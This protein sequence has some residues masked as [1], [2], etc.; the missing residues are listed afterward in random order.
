MKQPDII[1][2][3]V[4]ACRNLT[5]GYG[6]EIVLRDVNLTIPQGGVFLPFV[7]PNG[8]GKTTLLRAILGLIRPFSGTI[9]T[10][11]SAMAPGYV[12]QQNAIDVLY[13]VSVLD[14]VLMGAYREMKWHGRTNRQFCHDE[15]IRIL[16]NFGMAD[17][18]HKTFD[19]LSGGMRQK[20]MVMRALM[21]GSPYLIMDEP[22]TEL[23]SRSQKE[24]L[25]ILHQAAFR[26]GKTVLLV[27]HGMDIIS[28]LA[29]NVCLVSGGQ[30]TI[31]PTEAAHF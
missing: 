19:Q 13:P 16:E 27:H 2:E 8:A 12:S 15:A 11:F 21:S 14:I 17:S 20:T 4:I 29:P 23:D 31:M 18:R 5:L 6:R 30:A 1:N 26:E 25:E 7:G 3:G 22:T 10:P 24:L 9:M 28:D